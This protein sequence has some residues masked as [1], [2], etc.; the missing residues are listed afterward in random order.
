ML[1]F[2]SLVAGVLAL[3]QT[4]LRPVESFKVAMTFMYSVTVSDVSL[5]RTVSLVCSGSRGQW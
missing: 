1:N 2:T 3:W 5:S 4:V